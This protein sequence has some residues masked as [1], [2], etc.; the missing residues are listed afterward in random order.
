MKKTTSVLSV[1][2]LTATMALTGCGIVEDAIGE[3]VGEGVGDAIEGQLE[4]AIESETGGEVDLNFDG[5]GAELP[6]SFPDGVPVP[7]GL[8]LSSVGS[9]DGWNLSMQLESRD[10]FDATIAELE[11]QGYTLEEELDQPAMTLRTFTNG[12]YDVSLGL[13]SDESGEEDIA[14]ATVIVTPVASE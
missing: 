1:G 3:R 12:E 9:E 5:S 2:V 6:S 13:I 10:A 8:I 11:A 4:S 7:E 14:L